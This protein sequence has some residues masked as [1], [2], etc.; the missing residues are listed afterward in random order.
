MCTEAMHALIRSRLLVKSDTARRLKGRG[1]IPITCT[2]SENVAS[3]TF[4][5]SRKSSTQIGEKCV[6]E[7]L[8]RIT[9]MTEVY[10][11]PRAMAMLQT[12]SP[13]G[14]VAPNQAIGEW[15]AGGIGVGSDAHRIQTSH[16]YIETLSMPCSS[17]A[18]LVLQQW[19]RSRHPRP[20]HQ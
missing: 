8:H 14:V 10:G 3:T 7:P 1:Q 16:P 19:Q 20:T 18:A 6:M 12:R 17:S 4:S 13:G 5:T 9:R 15:C 11:P 2:L